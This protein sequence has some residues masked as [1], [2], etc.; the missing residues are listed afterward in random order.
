M[1][2]QKD[3]ENTLEIQ[4]LKRQIRATKTDVRIESDEEDEDQDD[5][6]VASFGMGKR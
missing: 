3:T 5:D 4:R 2:L 6:S 1:N